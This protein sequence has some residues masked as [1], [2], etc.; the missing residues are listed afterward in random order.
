MTMNAIAIR[1]SATLQAEIDATATER[2]NA[3]AELT[4]LDAKWREILLT[5]DDKAA[6][7]CELEMAKVRRSIARAEAQIAAL[8]DERDRASERE[9]VEAKAAQLAEAEAAVTE[10]LRQLDE[11]YE[12]ARRAITAFLDVWKRADDL[13]RAA[14]I[15][16]PEAL[17]RSTPF[18]PAT[19]QKVEREVWVDQHGHP[20]A[21]VLRE[22]PRTGQ[23]EAPSKDIRKVKR[24]ETLQV[25]A[26]GGDRLPALATSIKLPQARV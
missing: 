5:D 20:C 10:A 16:T 25:P 1:N 13:A 7:R 26:S 24:M 3:A 15:R 4:A 19:E 6:E 23:M 11:V 14:G 12:P 2:A 21:V 22:N 18:I 9:A 17:A 8:E